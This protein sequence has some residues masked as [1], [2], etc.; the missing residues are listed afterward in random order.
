M[1]NKEP[2]WWPSGLSAMSNCLRNAQPHNDEACMSISVYHSPTLS[3]GREDSRSK[4]AR[5]CQRGT[6]NNNKNRWSQLSIKLVVKV[7]Q[8]MET[9]VG[10][11]VH[12]SSYKQATHR[13]TLLAFRK[14]QWSA[15]I[16]LPLLSTY[17][18]ISK[19]RRSSSSSMT[20]EK[21]INFKELLKN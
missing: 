18:M 5:L 11:C 17:P 2:L 3:W 16:L 14:D 9:H 8:G 21:R 20:P 19:R 4:P 6:N 10:L 12:K 1:K 13:L 15:S 7:F